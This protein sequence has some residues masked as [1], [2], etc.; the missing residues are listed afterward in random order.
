MRILHLLSVNKFLPQLI[1]VSEAANPGNNVFAVPEKSTE[2]VL[3]LSEKVPNVVREGRFSDLHLLQADVEWCE[4]IF[5][6]YMTEDAAELVCSASPEKVIVWCAFGAD[7]YCYSPYY[8]DRL[9][10]DRT[11]AAFSISSRQT[12][13]SKLKNLNVI[14][15]ILGINGKSAVPHWM[16]SVAERIDCFSAY[17]DD[18]G[19]DQLI[20]N[21][22]PARLSGFPYYSIE[23]SFAP[24]PSDMCGSDVLLGNSAFDTNNHL[25]AFE[26][27]RSLDLSGRKI[28]LPLSY[29]DEEYARIISEKAISVFG[30]NGVVLLRQ[31]MPID[32]YNTVTASCG[33]VVMNHVRGQAMGNI[34]AA[35]YRGA[36]V[37]LRP[38]NP[39]YQGLKKDGA[40]IYPFV[41]DGLSDAFTE[42]LSS[43]ERQENAAI[44][45]DMWSGSRVEKRARK[46]FGMVNSHAREKQSSE[47]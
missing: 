41:R 9:L 40:H 27:L 30:I 23:S 15:K 3:R 47:A 39:Y 24:G 14:S 42:Q 21:F 17:E 8:R 16:T 25:D 32:E 10:L 1:E 18:L 13:F 4:A 12:V 35:L 38:E 29:G 19:I 22:Q 20:P 43:V 37:F 46:F 6:H 11:I 28:V 33:I 34:C 2:M 36:K 31:W 45:R 7:Y 5:V 44:M 26:D